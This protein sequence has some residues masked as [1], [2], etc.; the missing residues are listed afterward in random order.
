MGSRRRSLA[1]LLASLA[2]ALVSGQLGCYK[3]N[4]A[5]GGLRCNVD[6]GTKSCP[7]GFKCDLTSQR[8]YRNP[9]GGPD[10]SDADANIDRMPDEPMPICYP[11]RDSCTPGSG[12]CDPFCR[13]GCGC[14]EKCSVNTDG[15]LTCNELAPGQQRTLMQ[16]CQIQS[17]KTLD[18][19]DQ[20]APGLVCLEDSCSGGSSGRCYQFCRTNADC[21]DAPCDKTIGGGVKVCDVPFDD[22]TPLAAGANTGCPGT[23]LGCWLST[24]DPSK[25]IC[26]CQFP[27][28]L[29]EDDLC[30]RSRECNPGLVCVDR[31]NMGFKSCTRVCRLG[32]ASDCLGST[33]ATYSEG[34]VSN[35]TYGFCRF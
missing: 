4:I 17:A 29:G 25:T 7:E 2:A 9:D 19:T 6:A 33:C 10:T 30:M 34:G 15:A 23:A 5:D 14:R 26:D 31:N 32:V 20:C 8:C 35:S 13:T 22:C 11:P 28:G 3:P 21:T 18:Q 1:P 12:M 24:S 27:P 16:P